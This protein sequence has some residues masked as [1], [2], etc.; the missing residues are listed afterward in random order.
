MKLSIKKIRALCTLPIL[1]LLVICGC[2]STRVHILEDD[3]AKARIDEPILLFKPITRDSLLKNVCLSLGSFYSIELPKRVNGQVVYSENVDAMG[4]AEERS[5]IMKNGVIN[6]KEVAAIAS[7]LGCNSALTVQLIEIKRY[8]P[9]RMVIEL[10]WID[11]KTGD[12][13]G[14]LYQDVD[15]T[16]SETNY[17]FSNF[18]GQGPAKEFYERFFYSQDLYQSAY[19]SPLRFRHFVAA[20]TTRVLF[21]DIGVVP[22]WIFWRSF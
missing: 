14:K 2:T 12:V 5:N 17:R 20:Y 16:D 15:L 11:S 18:V 9:F 22:W 3:T 1:S 19:L 8:P 21:G 6:T 13:I 4:G 10:L 7:T